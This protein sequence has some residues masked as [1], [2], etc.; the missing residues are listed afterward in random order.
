MFC[1]GYLGILE[2]LIKKRLVFSVYDNPLKHDY[3]DS[4]DMTITCNS[5]EQLADKIIYYIDNLKETEKKIEE[6]YDFAKLQTWDKVSNIY[7]RLWG[8]K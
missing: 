6:G 2:S 8:I 1:T 3:L 4:L 7:L 5:S